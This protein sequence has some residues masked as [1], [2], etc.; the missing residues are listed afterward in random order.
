MGYLIL[1]TDD[2]S[3]MQM[4]SIQ[5]LFV[6]LCHTLD[7]CISYTV[8]DNRKGGGNQYIQL[9]KVLYHKLPTN[10]KELITSFP[11]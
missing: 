9:V 11:T 10:P 8:M 1:C 2:A 5:D 6:V 4:L 3:I 7:L